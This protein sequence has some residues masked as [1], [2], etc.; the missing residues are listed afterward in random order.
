MPNN[1]NR[2]DPAV[3]MQIDLEE[4]K[5]TTQGCINSCTGHRTLC[6]ALVGAAIFATIGGIVYAVAG[7]HQ[8]NPNTT[9]VPT[10]ST[11]NPINP[12]FAMYTQ[13]D[14]TAADAFNNAVLTAATVAKKVVTDMAQA[15]YGYT[16]GSTVENPVVTQTAQAAGQAI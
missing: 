10:S 12:K 1:Q 13:Q 5:K 15:A 4:G 9:V 8:D 3:R 2:N 16:V 11:V 14:K 7:V 6:C